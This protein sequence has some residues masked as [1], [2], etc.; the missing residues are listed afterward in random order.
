MQG[1]P[2]NGPGDALKENAK[3]KWP[4]QGGK[5]RKRL[6]KVVMSLRFRIWLQL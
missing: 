4:R 2:E 1:I 3:S 6:G 5:R